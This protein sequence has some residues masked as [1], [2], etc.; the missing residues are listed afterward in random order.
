MLQRVLLATV[1]LTGCATAVQG[2]D[3]TDASDGQSGTADSGGLGD[4]TGSGA[5]SPTMPDGGPPDSAPPTTSG[6][7]LLTEVV[8][9]PTPGEL[10]E[11]ANP[12]TAAVDLSNSYVSDAGAYFRLPAGAPTLDGGDFIAKF[13][14]GTSIPAHGVITIALDTAAN[15]QTTYAVAP[16]FVLSA[17]TMVS[18]TGTPSLTNGGELVVLFTWD[19]AADNVRD[20]DMLLVGVPTVAN[21]MVDKSG[22]VVDGPDP[23][24]TGTA[25]K[26]DAMTIAV[27][28]AAPGSGKSTKRV[29]PEPT[30][31]THAGTGNGIDGHDETS[32]NTAQTWDTGAGAPTPGTVPAGLL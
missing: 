26:V 20:V 1:A 10:I 6:H 23:D 3:G 11:I 18:S 5:G 32:E 9:A 13:P 14:T 19:G 24:T 25:Y 31:E 22:V 12:G 21:S 15:F 4:S 30:Y 17:M 2:L 29:A 28:A 7:L 8:L 27:Q 16:T